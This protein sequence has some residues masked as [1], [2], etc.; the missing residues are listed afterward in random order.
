MGFF[1]GV[2][3]EFDRFLDR[4]IGIDSPSTREGIVNFAGGTLG[5]ATG[6]TQSPLVGLLSPET[7]SSATSVGDTSPFP[8]T[9]DL[10]Q[11]R[12]FRSLNRKNRLSQTNVTGG[13][14]SRAPTI[15]P[16]L[17]TL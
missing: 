6:D 17:F 14:S 7:G 11:T 3:K 9:L 8:D 13:L 16:T 5:A 10:V 2:F 12:L 1:S 15:K 4:R